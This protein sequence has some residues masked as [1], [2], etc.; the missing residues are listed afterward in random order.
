MK[1]VILVIFILILLSAIAYAGISSFFNKAE[2]KPTIETAE[3]RKRDVSSSIIAT[4]SVKPMIGAEVKV[5]SR[6][7]GKVDLL[8]ANI[9]DKV[10]TGQ[11]IAEIEKQ[12]LQAQ[13][14]QA[15]AN[16][17]AGEA[18]VGVQQASLWPTLNA[19]TALGTADSRYFPQTG[20][21]SAGL[22][23]SMPIFNGQDIYGIRQA[24]ATKESL[25]AALDYAKVQLSYATIIAPIDGVISYVST[26][27]GETVVAGLNAPI[28]VTIIDLERLQVDAFVDETD[29][30]RVKVGQKATFTVDTYPGEEF[31]GEVM[32]IYPKAIIQENVVNYDV[33]VRITDP[34]IE[35]LRPDMTASVKIFQEERKGILAIPRKYIS[36]EEG[37]RVIYVLKENGKEPQRRIIKTGWQDSKNTE[38]L[39]GLSEGEKIVVRRAKVRSEE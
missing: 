29:I 25:K 3:A 26:Q 38:V 4:G 19:A 9:G 15:A 31:A 12:D 7:S 37:D 13:V 32:A 14:S 28:F 8:Y 2:K 1:K 10:K 18:G 22:V 6:I 24:K 16:L 5:G 35:L 27:Q 11:V 39:E 33:V 30:G 34:K 17:R 20:A 36:T 21:N 23:A